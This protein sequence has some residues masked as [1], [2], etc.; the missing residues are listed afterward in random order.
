MNGKIPALVFAFAAL[1][2]LAPM[3]LSA[4]EW[5]SSW[6][7]RGDVYRTLDFSVRAAIDRATKAFEKAL[8]DDESGRLS[9]QD[10]I[11]VYRAAAAEWRKVQ[12]QSETGDF[13]ER[14][15]AYSVFLQGCARERARDSNEALKLYGEVIELYP[16]I[17]YASLPAKFRLGSLQIAMGEG[18]KA[19]ITLGD[20]LDDPASQGSLIRAAA[21]LLAGDRLWNSGKFVE[22]EKCWS[23]I[24]SDGMKFAGPSR[25]SRARDRLMTVAM[26]SADFVRLD[27]LSML[28][29]AD[30]NQQ[31]Y[32]A[33]RM[34]FDFSRNIIGG[35]QRH[36]G[37]A[38]RLSKLCP[39]ES[40]RKK[41]NERVRKAFFPWFA[42]KRPMYEATGRIVD[43]LSDA[44]IVAMLSGSGKEIDAKTADIEKFIRARKYDWTSLRI[45][46]SAK[47]ILCDA[48]RFD[49]ARRFPELLKKPLDAA[50]MRYEIESRAGKP[51]AAVVHL[52]EYLALKPPPD[53]ARRAKRELAGLCRDHLGKYDKA[54]A[55]YQELNDPPGTL[56]DLHY[57]YRKAGRKNESYQVLTELE[58]VFPREAP[59]AFLIHAQCLEADGKIKQA[60]ALYRRLLSQ[61][62]WKKTHES[63]LAHQA[64]ERHGIATGGAVV[65]EAR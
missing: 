19:D 51:A 28:D 39:S 42:S 24:I 59:R 5:S 30:N 62:E 13:D 4:W 10:R 25:R 37:Y 64:L 32:E 15:I 27:E 9:E 40:E 57:T 65:N 11:S 26:V 16:D 35:N 38:W 21:L 63:S 44:L 53:N 2:A 54:I 36:M 23:E 52:E 33:A 47:N 49:Q 3:R 43:Y 48:R 8:R 20:L 60:I 61:P 56:W 7:L 14:V 58:S 18:R 31:R 17:V 55:I 6:R 46:H 50:W 12:V 41:R 34:V 45:A 29:R 1:A 22:G